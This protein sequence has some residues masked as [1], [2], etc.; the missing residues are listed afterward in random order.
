M[1]SSANIK[2]V[3]TFFFWNDEVC[4]RC[5][6]AICNNWFSWILNLVCKKIKHPPVNSTQLTH[7][8]LQSMKRLGLLFLDIGVLSNGT[9]PS[10]KQL[11]PYH[12]WGQVTFTFIS[13]L[14]NI[15][16]ENK[17]I[18]YV[19]KSSVI[20][21]RGQW[22]KETLLHCWIQIHNI[23]SSWSILVFKWKRQS[24]HDHCW[25]RG[26]V[27]QTDLSIN[28][29][30]SEQAFSNM[31]SDCLAAVLYVCS[32]ATIQQ[33]NNVLFNSLT[34]RRYDWTLKH[35]IDTS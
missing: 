34:T 17:I 33:C 32:N 5:Q 6:R 3:H 7:C 12:K 26:L 9:M 30:A 13:N 1:Q 19:F 10:P 8:S 31:A 21:S 20:Y 18:N 28:S 29:A 15:S 25:W 22:V 23:T 11:L 14:Q 16:S 2:Q 27:L 4:C 35:V 24:S